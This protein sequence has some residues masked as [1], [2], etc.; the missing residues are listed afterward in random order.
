M[1]EFATPPKRAD[2]YSGALSERGTWVTVT[3]D[4]GIAWPVEATQCVFRGTTLHI[5]PATQDD[6][7]P[8]PHR[9]THTPPAIAVK[10]EAGLDTRSA[11]I[12]IQNFLSSLVWVTKSR[13]LID[14]WGGGSL[15][16]LSGRIGSLGVRYVTEEFEHLYLPDPPE[17]EKKW[18]LA[19]YREGLSLPHIAY[20]SLSY[21]KV[22]NLFLRG[23]AVIPWINGILPKLASNR[24]REAKD[25][26]ELI[27]REK[28]PGEYC[29]G[30]IRCA[31][32]HAGE[33]PTIDPENPDDLERLTKD[34]PILRAL[35]EYAIESHFGIESESTVYRKH[36][37]ELS[38]F[39][40]WWGPGVSERLK[41]KLPIASVEMR[42]PPTITISLAKR[43]SYPS[44]E[45]IKGSILAMKDG[46]V[47]LAY[48][49]PSCRLS[50][51]IDLNFPEERLQLD[52]F[53]MGVLD[54][55]T[56]AAASIHLD[57]L[58]FELDYLLNGRLLICN[59]ETGQLLGRCDAYLPMNVDLNRSKA[60]YDKRIEQQQRV[61]DARE[62]ANGGAN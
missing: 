56:F 19:F 50:I 1:F 55:N 11:K 26:A 48:T 28:N 54:D 4:T 52:A 45:N 57:V 12:L 42:P 51:L 27:A 25:V 44:F 61:V 23:K 9:E 20:R 43:P 46:L 32:A 59:A 38:G 29:Y 5:L 39:K 58:K 21:F 36:L 31:V 62:N 2:V 53:G 6:N 15:P 8:A 30:A 49:S 40:D 13:A 34:L 14:S 60:N 17:K 33:N 18:A 35:A 7:G 41:T 16:Y 10:I 3:L 47:R 24:A 37:Y 22:L